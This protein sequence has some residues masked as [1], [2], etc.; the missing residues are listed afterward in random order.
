MQNG[1]PIAYNVCEVKSDKNKHLDVQIYIEEMSVAVATDISSI[2]LHIQM[3]IFIRFY[4]ANVV[5]NWDPILH[6][7][8]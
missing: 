3:L 5:S 7:M 6:F 1:I 4:F 2:Y 8:S